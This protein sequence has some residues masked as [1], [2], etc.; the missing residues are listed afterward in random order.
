MVGSDQLDT[1]GQVIIGEYLELREKMNERQLLHIEWFGNA[2]QVKLLKAMISSI[3]SVVIDNNM[4]SNLKRSNPTHNARNRKKAKNNTSGITGVSYLEDRGA[5]V[6]KITDNEG[7]R[8]S[9]QFDDIRG[10]ELQRQKWEKQ[11]G[12]YK[13]VSS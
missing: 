9:M 2:W 1:N 13:M 10:A 7:N 3:I 6:A 5:Y 11:F 4:M 8:I 12:G